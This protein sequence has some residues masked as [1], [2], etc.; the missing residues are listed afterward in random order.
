MR[1]ILALL[2]K[3]FLLFVRDRTDL[4][5]TFLVPVVLIFIFGQIFGVNRGKNGGFGLDGASTIRVGLVVQTTAPVVAEI[6][7]A[8]KNEKTF[9]IVDTEKDVAGHS[10]PITEERMRALLTQGKLRF[11]VIFPPDADQGA[12][13]GLHVRFLNNPVNDIENGIVTGMVQKVVYSTAPVALIRALPERIAAELGP[14]PTE[15]FYRSI[16]KTAG[17]TF[18]VDP[19]KIYQAMKTGRLQGVVPTVAAPDK[20]PASSPSQG[21]PGDVLSQLVRIDAE[22]VVGAQ[23]K[24]PMATRLVGGWAMMFLLFSVSSSATGL[25]NEKKAGL[26]VRLLSMPVRRTHILWSKYLYGMTLGLIQ[27]TVMFFAGN[28]LFGIDVAAHLGN[29][30]VAVLAASAACTAFG[31]LL[32]SIAPSPQAASGLATLII[33]TMSALGGAWF[34][35]TMM[36]E[37]LQNFSQLTIVYWSINAFQQVLWA[38]QPLLEILPTIGIL[39]GFAAVANA[40]SLWRFTRGKLFE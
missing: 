10:Q 28:L 12:G 22:Q 34:P 20:D 4:V 33:L 11:A 24:N 32:A 15:E 23:V 36:P 9:R 25:F 27:L 16:A 6:A 5:I 8:L 13:F 37:W 17:E 3:D 7:N 14:R 18:E 26:F 21:G 40:F 19:E 31:M 38:Q 2:R 35:T 30:L 39:L 1:T 29:L